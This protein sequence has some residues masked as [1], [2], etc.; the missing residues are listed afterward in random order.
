LKD[1]IME[2]KRIDQSVLDRLLMAKNLIEKIRSLPEAN[3]DR[4]TIALHTLAAHDAAELAIAAVAH[5]VGS[6]PKP[7]EAYLMKY[8]SHIKKIHPNEG[9][10]GQDYFSQLNDVRVGVKHK[11]IFPD[12][13]QWL[14][15]GDKVY[16]Y[17]SEWCSSYL[18]ISFD[19]LDESDMI[20]D[21]DVKRQYDAARDA[22]VRGAFKS[23][24]EALALGLYLLF[25]RNR[26]LRSL[27]VGIPLAEDALKLSAFGVHANE[28]L[29]LQEFLPTVSYSTV[30]GKERVSWERE[31]YG[32]PANWRKDAVGFCLKT[33]VR[34]ALCIQ[35]A[36]WIPG[37]IDFETVY[38]HKVTALAGR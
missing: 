27:H 7:S 33:F 4:Y 9:V 10:A 8:F 29:M 24:L 31:K 35:D 34:V 17:I 11:G 1:A 37:P 36:E 3:P 6:I 16:S 21:S 32:H 19:E 23:A 2:K 30:D 22:L 12:P 28:F 38:E 14:R 18:K 15:V 26:A 20:T 13:K 25:D 5:H